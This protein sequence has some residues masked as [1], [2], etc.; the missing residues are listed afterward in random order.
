VMGGFPHVTHTRALQDKQNGELGIVRS[1]LAEIAQ[2]RGVRG[3]SPRQ[4]K[5]LIRP[6]P[7]P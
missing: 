3:S 7:P 6:V 4:A 5:R 1:H 2:S